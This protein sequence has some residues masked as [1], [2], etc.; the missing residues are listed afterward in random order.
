V[1]GRNGRI[2]KGREGAEIIQT[3]YTGLTGGG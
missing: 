2:M 1:H 3:L